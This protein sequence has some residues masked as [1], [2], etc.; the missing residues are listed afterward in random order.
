MT[1]DPT[2][3]LAAFLG[4]IINQL[5]S[6]NSA[7]TDLHAAAL[8]AGKPYLA[9]RLMQYQADL[10]HEWWCLREEWDAMTDRD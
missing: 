6:V 5:S 8:S 10:A 1:T 3:E 7:M 2:P 4:R 9:H